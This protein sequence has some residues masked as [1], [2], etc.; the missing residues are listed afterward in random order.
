[1]QT[2]QATL[3]PSGDLWVSQDI[4][5][6]KFVTTPSGYGTNYRANPP[7]SVADLYPN[8]W[9]RVGASWWRDDYTSVLVW[10]SGLGDMPYLIY[11][12]RANADWRRRNFRVFTST[13]L[14]FQI[15]VVAYPARVPL[16]ELLQP[17][18]ASFHAEHGPAH[19]RKPLST[20]RMLQGLRADPGRKTAYGWVDHPAWDLYGSA[21]VDRLN[22][23]LKTSQGLIPWGWAYLGEPWF[24]YDSE[25]LPD[26]L[27]EAVNRVPHGALVR[28]GVVY[29]RNRRGEINFAA[30]YEH[31]PLAAEYQ[32]Q[33]VIGRSHVYLDDFGI[34]HGIGTERS[35]L[36]DLLLLRHW[37]KTKGLT[38]RLYVEFPSDRSL[39]Y[40]DGYLQLG[41]ANGTTDYW[42][43]QEQ[44]LALRT[45]HPSSSFIV[46]RNYSTDVLLATQDLIQWCD[47]NRCTPLVEDWIA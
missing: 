10:V 34:G 2:Y 24:P 9:Y 15:H 40:A 4:R 1:M 14:P 7:T 16:D 38:T 17:W 44:F 32:I 47:A 46:A 28:P 18:V 19:P 30:Q 37:T 41:G 12:D 39:L 27:A 36:D 43:G 8:H 23:R 13:P 33:R 31:S 22:D 29:S 21:W 25:D 11:W 35:A 45:L 3:R 6:P 42:L 5:A 20:Q 26:H